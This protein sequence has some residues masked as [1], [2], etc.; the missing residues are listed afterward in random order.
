MGIDGFEFLGID[1]IAA[2]RL[3]DTV[4]S[5]AET[6]GKAIPP[7]RRL[8]AYLC[9]DNNSAVGHQRGVGQPSR[10]GTSSMAML[11]PRIRGQ[12]PS[13]GVQ[14]GCGALTP[15]GAVTPDREAA[16]KT[17]VPPGCRPLAQLCTNSPSAVCQQQVA[18]A[19]LGAE[20]LGEASLAGRGGVQDGRS[21]LQEGGGAATAGPW[22]AQRLGVALLACPLPAIAPA[23]VPDGFVS[24]IPRPHPTPAAVR[25]AGSDAHPISQL[26]PGCLVFADNAA[27]DAGNPLV[28]AGIGARGGQPRCTSP[29]HMERAAAGPASMGHPDCSTHMSPM[30]SIMIRPSATPPVPRASRLINI[31]PSVPPQRGVRRTV[32]PS[33][34]GRGDF[35]RE[36]PPT[37]PA[38][39]ASQ[40]HRRSHLK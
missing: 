21:G 34:L 25:S 14:T 9:S 31:P 17:M 3:E 5:V 35:T 13:G 6:A 38:P 23:R 27:P 19:S 16:S 29:Q 22:R 12:V 36:P 20:P 40:G 32:S 30:D 10:A 26:R 37:S 15:G 24:A 39:P 28:G 11:Q 33:P 7:G 1:A 2:A 4:R 8:L 18:G